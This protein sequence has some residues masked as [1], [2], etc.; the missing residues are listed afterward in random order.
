MSADA[1]TN[2]RL[3]LEVATAWRPQVMRGVRT[4]PGITEEKGVQTHE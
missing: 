2:R 3:P 1:V 4:P